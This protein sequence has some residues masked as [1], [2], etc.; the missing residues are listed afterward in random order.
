MVFQVPTLCEPLCFLI[1][2]FC[3]EN[4]FV[5]DFPAKVR[6]GAFFAR[7][8]MTHIAWTYVLPIRGCLVCIRRERTQHGGLK[9]ELVCNRVSLDWISR[10][11]G[12]FKNDILTVKPQR[13]TFVNSHMEY[14]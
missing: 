2:G 1:E 13:P 3:K 8:L 6:V 11:K 5:T 9:Y 10:K 12:R 4:M 7:A 14:L